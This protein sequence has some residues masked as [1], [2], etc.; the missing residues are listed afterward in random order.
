MQ[1][2]SA[3]DLSVPRQE[4]TPS[5]EGFGKTVTIGDFVRDIFLEQVRRTCSTMMK[6]WQYVFLA[7]SR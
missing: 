4:I 1:N 7:Y 5:P 6:T 3:D 2:K